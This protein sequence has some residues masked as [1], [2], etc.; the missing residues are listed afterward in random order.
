LM[1]LQVCY[2]NTSCMGVTFLYLPCMVLYIEIVLK[3]ADCWHLG[4]LAAE[5]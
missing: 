5:T 2:I 4:C 1:V 3:V